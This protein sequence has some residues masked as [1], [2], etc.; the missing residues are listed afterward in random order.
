MH[1]ITAG[2]LFSGIGGLDLGFERA[3]IK[4]IWQVECDRGC[5]H[6]LRRH[7]PH[8]P[9]FTDVLTV[10]ANNLPAVDIIHGG[11]P[12]TDLSSAGLGKGLAGARS[13]LWRSFHR[14]ISELKPPFVVVENVCGLLSK[15]HRSDFATILQ[16]LGNSG[17]RWSY[18]VFD[19]Q[20]FGLNQRR[21]RLY[22]VAS[23]GNWR[24]AEVLF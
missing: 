14:I 5:Q 13:G 7:F 8:T 12:C 1:P 9:R 3:G 15:S 24:C 17:Y 10:G 20:F 16:G 23:F 21:R 18:R 22:I 19:S 4:S 2:S 11:F 6:I